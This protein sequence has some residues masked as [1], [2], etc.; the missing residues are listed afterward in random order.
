MDLPT[1]PPAHM[2]PAWMPLFDVTHTM[3]GRLKKSMESMAKPHAFDQLENIR[4]QGLP[5]QRVVG[6]EFFHVPIVVV[7]RPRAD[8]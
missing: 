4:D 7:H 2:P 6:V 1:I 8:V 5:P 3:T